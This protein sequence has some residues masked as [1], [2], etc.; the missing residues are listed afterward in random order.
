MEGAHWNRDTKSI[1]DT[2]NGQ[3][4][5]SMPVILMKPVVRSEQHHEGSNFYEAPVFRTSNR[6]SVT[7]K[8]GHSTN[9]ITFFKLN[10]LRQPSAHWIFRGVAL[11]C[12]LDD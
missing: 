12:Q 11:L 7:M 3:F 2:T 9:F 6:Q 8:S 1:E 10:T 4:H 5:S